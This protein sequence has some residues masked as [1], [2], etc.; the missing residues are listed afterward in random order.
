M[1]SEIIHLANLSSASIR[2][3]A[4]RSASKYTILVLNGDEPHI[5]DLSRRRWEQVMGMSGATMSYS[6][7]YEADGRLHPLIVY[8]HGS[9]RDDFDFGPMV[10][11]STGML[12]KYV[13]DADHMADNYEFGGWYSLRLYLSRHGELLHIPEALYAMNGRTEKPGTESAHFAYV[14]PRNRNY[15]IEM[16]RIATLHLKK[17]GAYV[18]TSSLMTVDVAEG[19]FPVEASVII[20]VRNRART[21]RDAVRSALG[22]ETTFDFNVIVVDNRSTDGTSDILAGL[23]KEDSRLIVITTESIGEVAPGIGGCWN[24]A[25]NSP[26]CGRFAVQLDSDDIYE[27][28]KT[29]GKIVAAFRRCNCA[30]VIGSYTLTDID[31]RVLPPGLIDHREWTDSNGTN[32]ALRINGLGAPRAFF[33]PVVREIGFPDVCYG[34]DYSMGLAISGRY[35]VG[36]IFESLYLCRRWEDNTDHSLSVE[37]INRNNYYKDFIRSMEMRRRESL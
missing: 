31:G 28:P 3:A 29:L 25:I 16:E 7:Y 37:R 1:E 2:E 4:E 11:I 26:L 23:A 36:R 24:I 35:R 33:T 34:E 14:D 17:T 15:Q 32:N 20:P 27:S 10:M 30:M 21:I 18:D 6:D 8:Q 13:E 12:R 19:T 5:S 22:Q 9:V